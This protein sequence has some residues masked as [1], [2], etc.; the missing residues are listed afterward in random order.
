[1][2]NWKKVI[3]I[4]FDIETGSPRFGIIQ[5]STLFMDQNGLDLRKFESSYCKPSVGAVF[6]PQA[7]E[8]HGIS[9]R[10]NL[11][12]NTSIRTIFVR[13]YIHYI[14]YISN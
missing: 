13:I 2:L 9:S 7:C 10:T 12:P 14:L 8:C 1:M 5:L 3:W 11:L 6:L 4:S